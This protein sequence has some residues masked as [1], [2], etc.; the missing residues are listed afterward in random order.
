[1]ARVA[2]GYGLRESAEIG[3]HLHSESTIPGPVSD[4]WLEIEVGGI[5]SRADLRK[6]LTRLGGPGCDVVIPGAPEGELHVWSDPPKIMRIAG[7][8]E[9]EVE[10]RCAE[11]CPLESGVRIRWA[12]ITMVY[13]VDQ[14]VLQEIAFS[15]PGPAPATVVAR[16][17]SDPEDRA[18][19]RVR[20]GL[21]IDLGLVEKRVVG[22]WQDVV[23]RQEF[24]ADACARE[25]LA[26]TEKFTLDDPRV[27][28]RSGR[29]LRD[30][31]MTSLHR[32]VKGATR[33]MRS[34]AV[35]GSA[36]LM[37]N[38]IGILIYTG[39]VLVVMLLARFKWQTSFDAL[40]D[41]VLGVSDS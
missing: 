14:P 33:K 38:A 29:L 41:T 22:R 16:R 13:K 28:E 39:I 8:A 25:I 11:E 6:G 3:V 27:I 21:A 4:A 17:P 26:S 1:V 12:A 18:W 10:G 36:F 19:Q 23:L 20:A 40:F 5:R 24:D 9:L 34:Q 15:T 32:G 2:P 37:A 35:S 31:L 7:R 30:F